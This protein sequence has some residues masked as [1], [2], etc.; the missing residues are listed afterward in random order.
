MLTLS[1]A[2]SARTIGTRRTSTHYQQR[3]MTVESVNI[4]TFELKTY[5]RSPVQCVCAER[6][7]DACRNIRYDLR[8]PGELDIHPTSVL[9]EEIGY[10]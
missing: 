1:T 4:K 5:N 6:E 7:S 2:T 8:G 9:R 10:S 3:I